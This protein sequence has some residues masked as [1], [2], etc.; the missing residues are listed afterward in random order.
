MSTAVGEVYGAKNAEG[1]EAIWDL[2]KFVRQMREQL[3]KRYWAREVM[4][5][6]MNLRNGRR[7][8]Y[9]NANSQWALCIFQTALEWHHGEMGLI[10]GFVVAEKYDI[11][12]IRPFW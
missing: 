7:W 10:E 3:M 2:V 1:M 11:I 4:T 5:F 9:E 8:R 6:P 12:C